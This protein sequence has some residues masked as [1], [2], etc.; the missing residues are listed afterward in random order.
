MY[1]IC[2]NIFSGAKGREHDC[3]H[4]PGLFQCHELWSEFEDY[5]LECRN[6]ATAP[7][8]FQEVQKEEGAPPDSLGHSPL[9]IL[10]FEQPRKSKTF[11]S[12]QITG[13]VSFPRDILV[14]D[15]FV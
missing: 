6:I 13:H 4:F 5:S 2:T 12:K 15:V 3:T 10:A 9:H 1:I 11:F 7:R 14:T 8:N